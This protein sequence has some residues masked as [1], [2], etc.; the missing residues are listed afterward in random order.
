MRLIILGAGGFA[1]E[2]H[3]LIQDINRVAHSGRERVDS[4][5]VV[6]FID[7]NAEHH[8]IMLHGLP[9]LGGFE[10][11]DGISRDTF[12]A[13]GVG[14]PRA[15]KKFVDIA[16]GLGF[17]FATLIHPE[18]KMG[19]NVRIGTGV[20]VAAG[21]YFTVDIVVGDYAMI[22][23]NCTIGHDA[24]IGR[25]ASIQPHCT[26]AGYTVVGEGTELG[27]NVTTNPGKSIGAWS[28][29]GAG[30]VVVKDIPAGVVAVG[31]PAKVIRSTS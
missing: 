3:Y 4:I 10:W 19:E 18:T 23:L 15:K 28:L 2:V 21:N 1:R 12:L 11:L 9:I 14:S 22:N 13:L 26:I 17:R 24:S 29:M 7:E 20:V 16:L 5:E 30:A 27:S 31:I 6:G 25:F 8:G